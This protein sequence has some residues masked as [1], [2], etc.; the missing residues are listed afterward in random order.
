MHCTDIQRHLDEYLDG[1]LSP[2][3]RQA[4]ERHRAACES[5][6]ARV[7]RARR[8][9]EDLRELPVPPPSQGFAERVLAGARR[10]QGRRGAGFLAGFGTAAAA[11]LALWAAVALMPQERPAGPELAAVSIA[12]E[13]TRNVKVAFQAGRDLPGARI[14]I[15]LPDNV[16]LVGYPGRRQLAWRADLKAGANVLTLPLR[17]RAPARGELVAR[18]EYGDKVKTV[19]IP[20]RVE[21][22]ADAAV[23][24]PRM[25]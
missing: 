23:R 20:V 22:G 5:C 8:L 11:G 4:F 2:A 14:V 6:A 1:G 19:R 15:A 21:G 9:L 3:L 10:R 7:A 13:A 25:A 16:E 24:V 12:V 17:G 18:I